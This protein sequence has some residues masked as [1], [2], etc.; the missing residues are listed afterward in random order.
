M[1]EP[2]GLAQVRTDDPAASA[3]VLSTQIGLVA[4]RQEELSQAVQRL[5]A[6]AAEFDQLRGYVEQIG[7][8]LAS[9]AK[10]VAAQDVTTVQRRV[11]DLAETVSEVDT[12]RAEVAAVAEVAENLATAQV[13]GP[14]SWWPDLA[15]G[16]SRAEAL[17]NLAIWVDE[18]LRARHPEMYNQ[19]GACWYQHPDILDEMT[20]LRAAWYAAYRDPA[21]PATAAIEWHD[22]W[23]PGAMRRCRAAIRARGCKARHEKETPATVP[24]I[25]RQEFRN[26]VRLGPGTA[27]PVSDTA[28]PASAAAAPPWEPAPEPV[29]EPL[30]VWTANGETTPPL[31]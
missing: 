11:D 3:A 6:S 15:T 2:S 24:F 25:D 23:L 7:A 28:A 12:L 22:R 19:L 21:A 14:A 26:F 9:L 13:S 1:N 27:V 5:G 29:A 4:Q 31:E 16:D 8:I 18:V 17:Q 20:A 10:E 30:P